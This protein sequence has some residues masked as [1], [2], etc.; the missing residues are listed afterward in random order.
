[1]PSKAE[2]AKR[3]GV[4]RVRTKKIGRDRYVTV[5]VVRKPG[6]HGGRTVA[7]EVKR[8]KRRR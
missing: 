8:R 4:V 3:G 1:V 2:L 6:K 5:Y 7:G